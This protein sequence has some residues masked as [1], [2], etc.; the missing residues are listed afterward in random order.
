MS[1]PLIAITGANTEV[2]EATARAFSA[3]GYQLRQTVPEQKMVVTTTH[4]EY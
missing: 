1:T 4:R 2:G 3:N